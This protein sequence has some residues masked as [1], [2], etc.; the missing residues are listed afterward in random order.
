[1]AKKARVV[2][3]VK[4]SV[5]LNPGA[6]FAGRWNVYRTAGNFTINADQLE[7]TEAGALVF[8]VKDDPLYVFPADQYQYAAKL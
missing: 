4:S 7:V 8:L 1:M 2:K 5:E 6:N 3:P